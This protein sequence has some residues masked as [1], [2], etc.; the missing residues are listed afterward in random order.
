MTKEKYL[1]MMIGVLEIAKMLYA[2]ENSGFIGINPYAGRSGVQLREREF[3]IFF[4]NDYKV[5]LE[6]PCRI[7]TNYNGTQ[8]FTLTDSPEY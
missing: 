7:S 6:D 2:D 3:R 8:F 5:D 1:N 4:G